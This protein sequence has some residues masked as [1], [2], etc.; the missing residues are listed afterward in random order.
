MGNEDRLRAY[1]RRVTSDARELRA[2]L[3]RA[4]GRDREPV[5]V[6]GFGHRL[7]GDPQSEVDFFDAGLFDADFF[8]V[9]AH[10]VD[11]ARR[12]LLE[13]SWEAFEH[14]GIRPGSLAG[15]DTGVFVG[16]ST[17]AS[18]PDP[19]ALSGLVA[20]VLGLGGPALTVDTGCSAP[21]VALHLAVRALRRGECPL[22]L[23]G[24]AEG[25]LLLERLSDARRH[26]HPVRCV[27]R[28]SAVNSDG[29]SDGTARQHVVRAAL[30]DAGL[31]AD[32]VRTAPGGA[33]VIEALLAVRSGELPRRVGVS[34]FG[35][36]NAHVVLE[37]PEPTPE[38]VVTE[39]GPVA[40]PLSART[41]E[42]LRQATG[43][44]RAHLA[45]T[46]HSPAEVAAALARRT[47]FAHRAVVVGRDNAELLRALAGVDAAGGDADS[48]ATNSG[49]APGGDVIRGV[50]VPG[51]RVVFVLPG[52]GCEWPGMAQELLDTAPA[53]ATAAAE[54]AAALEP[55]VD[56]PV[57]DVLRGADG[58][59]P[60]D[61]VDVARPALFTDLVSLAALWRAHGVEPAA[62]LGHAEGAIAAAHVAGALS[63]A[64]AAALVADLSRV[65]SEPVDVHP[66]PTTT[67][68]RPTATADAFEDA[69][70]DLPD[71]AA[72]IEI[73]PHPVLTTTMAELAG[74]RA[75]V[76]GTLR[77]DDGGTR[78]FL[79]SLARAH[80]SGVE[81]TWPALTGTR[82]VDL[83][84]YPF[85]RAHH[86]FAADDPEPG[87]ATPADEPIAVVGMACRLPGDVAS[88]DDLWRLLTQ[89]RDATAPVP[90]DRAAA[91]PAGATAGLLSDVDGFDAAFFGFTTEESARLD[92]RGR[93]LLETSWEVLENAG[94]TPDALRGSRT[95]VFLGAGGDRAG[96]LPGRI[97]HAYGL[98]GPALAVDTPCSASLTAL[99]LACQSL[100][101]DECALAFAGGATVLTGAEPRTDPQRG[102]HPAEGVALV[103]LERLS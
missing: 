49:D 64:D 2:R 62:V 69:V 63:L 33:G 60:P 52:H 44:L 31:S 6:V 90:A 66:A 73:S 5:A 46:S 35:G 59:P 99:H 75:A 68:F 1:L 28:G 58:A 85:Q 23:V 103:L 54:C 45:D 78:R 102:D 18:S 98:E 26:G 71:H 50:A 94:V 30:H 80:V 65:R 48:S 88:P 87:P 32:Q 51:R 9:P 92:P 42:A 40:W 29:G 14:A 41:A 70:R 83:P 95:G 47:A 82:H 19:T 13:T 79:R 53:F 101:Q 37:A 20:R 17:G 3:D 43:R 24:G 84:T 16:A 67:P 91:L 74:D 61:R 34:A 86:R 7:P 10:R 39:V 96:A 38:P 27:V 4:E 12:L 15:G 21:L 97:S 11:P 93:L 8:D 100:R 36:G 89:G 22:A 72:L 76:L 56:F 81:V 57:L 77:R 25:V 55:H